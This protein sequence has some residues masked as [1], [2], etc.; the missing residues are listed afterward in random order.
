MTTYPV[1]DTEI[2]MIGMLE[3][4]STAYF[5]AA[6]LFIGGA[7]TIWISA[8]FYETVPPAAKLLTLFGAPVCLVIGLIFV[9]LG[10]MAWVQKR[11]IWVKIKGESQPVSLRVAAGGLAVTG[12]T[13]PSS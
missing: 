6:T 2:G 10:V 7:A 3:F 12:P 11:G 9:G 13:R 8:T 4:Q 1:N 5:S